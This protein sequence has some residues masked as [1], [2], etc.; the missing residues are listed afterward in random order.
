M[1]KIL[2]FLGMVAALLF[3]AQTSNAQKSS[4]K[5]SLFMEKLTVNHGGSIPSAV[6]SKDYF[7]GTVR[8][9]HLF[10]IDK[11]PNVSGA[12]VTFEPCA[13]TKWHTHPLGQMLI[14]TSGSGFVQEW[15]GKAK[16][17]TAGSS[18][19]IE[20]NVKHWHGGTAKNALT[21]IAITESLE[22]KNVTW[23]EEVTDEQYNKAQKDSEVK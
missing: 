3:T 19:W 22:G 10:P 11:S 9:D 12:Y 14:V 17:I 23:M 16:P 5:E 13:R 21:H 4:A 6:G 1:K 2:L 7:T 18:V 8:I 15:G 20:P